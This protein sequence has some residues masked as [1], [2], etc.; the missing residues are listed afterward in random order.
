MGSVVLWV[1]I[2]WGIS[3]AQHCWRGKEAR[4]E[5]G[6]RRVSVCQLLRVVV[7][8]SSDGGQEGFVG[9]RKLLQVYIIF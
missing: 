8:A 7:H 6:G 1:V 3:E 2:S 4:T 9:C 5:A